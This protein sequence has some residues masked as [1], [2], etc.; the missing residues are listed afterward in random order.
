MP[1]YRQ[2][3]INY[4][5]EPG[6]GIAVVSRSNRAAN[7]ITILAE[8]TIDDDVYVVTSIDAYAFAYCFNLRGVTIPGFVTSIGNNAFS[9][10]NRLMRITFT[11]ISELT[12]I[13]QFAFQSC[14]SLTSLAIPNSVTSIGQYAFSDC[15]SLTSLE[16]PNSVTSIE[17]SIIQG[18]QSL[19]SFKFSSS[20]TSINTYQLFSGCTSLISIDVDILNHNYSSLLGVLF[21]KS[22]TT[23]LVYPR[24]LIGSYTIPDSV[25]S[26]DLDAFGDCTNLTNVIIPNSVTSI[27]DSAFKSCANLT[28]VI[29]PNSVTSIGA[30]AFRYCVQ[31]TKVIISNFVTSIGNNA[32]ANCSNLAKLIIGTS[33]TYIG[34]YAFNSCNKL[35]NVL[36]LGDIIPTIESASWSPNF[37]NPSDTASYII[38]AENTD[39]LT[40]LFSIIRPLTRTQMDS[41]LLDRPSLRDLIDAGAT[42]TYIL[43]FGYT[44]TELK[45]AGFTGKKPTSKIELLH[46][47]SFFTPQAIELSTDITSDSP[48]SLQ[49]VSSN[50][51]RIFAS[52][53][54]INLGVTNKS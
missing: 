25:T 20:V 10:S 6:S 30:Q 49:N 7:N 38:G 46:S 48:F 19:T 36:F 43:S 47:L 40:N 4:T 9:G 44:L 15:I 14:S 23:L 27:G 35:T 11:P 22:A 2:S 45:N 12:N 51:I 52:I 50:P 24:G 31:F 1:I 41:A 32:F 34:N 16:I 37:D 18:C 13:G 3:D 42:E 39:I 29:I 8:F 5:Y 28:N 26:I 54:N 33:V 21:N 53:N 17:R